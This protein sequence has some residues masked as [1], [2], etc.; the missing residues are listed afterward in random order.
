[1]NW[2]ACARDLQKSLLSII[3]ILMSSPMPALGVTRAGKEIVRTNVRFLATS[4]SIRSS[5]AGNQ[6]VYLVQ[7]ELPGRAKQATLARLVDE[8]PSYRAA[9]PSEVLMSSSA[10]SFRL[11]R[12]RGCDITYGLMLLRT[13]PGDPMA[14]MPERL[15]FQPALPEPVTPTEILPCYDVVRR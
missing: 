8:Y 14:I 7:I 5:W 11:E 4:T 3:V 10:T 1:M 9:I 2:I 13:A 12:D 6:D 15:S